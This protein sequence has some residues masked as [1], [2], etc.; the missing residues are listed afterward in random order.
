MNVMIV[1]GAGQLG[2]KLIEV[3]KRETDWDIASVI[4]NGIA[5]KRGAEAFDTSSRQAWKRIVLEERWRP[6][7]IVNTAAMTD[8]DQCENRREEAWRTNVQLVEHLT[9]MARTIDARFVQ[10]SSDYVFDGT[11]GPYT[12]SARP[13]PINYYG[14]TKLAAE[15]ICMRSGAESVILRTMWLYGYADNGKQNFVTW[16]VNQ[17]MTT[18]SAR[19]VDD[20]IGNPTLTDDLAYAIVAVIEK[21]IRGVVNL[22]GPEVMSRLDFARKIAVE[23][24]LDPERLTPIASMELNRS[25]K[26]PLQSGLLTFKA[27][28]LLDIKLR[29]VKESLNVYRTQQKR[30]AGWR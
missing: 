30:H 1:G 22:A 6:N 29:T 10:I 27:Q 24:N 20:E 5:D 18:G 7:I 4:R 14:K 16:M 2:Q 21:D 15:N 26:R 28:S 19:I 23:Y 11:S 8:V 12:E 3:F 9:S 13:N 17:L 25:A